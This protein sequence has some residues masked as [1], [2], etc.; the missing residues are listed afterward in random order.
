MEREIKMRVLNAIESSIL[1]Y[2]RKHRDF[3]DNPYW[4][5]AEEL[6]YKSKNYIYFWFKERDNKKVGLEDLKKICE[7]TKDLTPLK[8][9][10]EEVKES[11]K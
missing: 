3:I 8:I 9:Y 5:F 6:G 10:V 7:I 1:Q 11:L 2:G 4:F